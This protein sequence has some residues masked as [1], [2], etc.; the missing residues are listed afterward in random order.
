MEARRVKD[1]DRVRLITR[2]G[3]NWTKRYPQIGCRSLCAQVSGAHRRHLVPR[4]LKLEHFGRGQER[5]G[6]AR[7][8]A[9]PQT[10]NVGP[11]A[12]AVRRR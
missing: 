12:D 6:G 2:G 10:A 7:G 11:A 4:R 8:L 9:S 3:Y 5:L 1:G